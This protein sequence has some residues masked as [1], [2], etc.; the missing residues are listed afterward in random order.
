LD[1]FFSY[2]AEL[3]KT[4]PP[5]PEDAPIVARMAE[6]GIVPGQEFDRSKL[7]KLGHKLDPKLALLELVHAMK[8]KKAVDGWLYWT[9][10]AGRYGTDYEQRA[11]VTV[12]GPGMNFAE[13]AVYAFSEKDADGKDYDGS[14]HAYVMRFEQ[15]QMPPVKGFWS[16]TMYDP[17]FFFVPNPIDR[18]CLSQRDTFVTNA[19]GSVDSYLQAESPGQDREA[20]WLPA[21]KGKFIPM[22][23]LYWP[24]DAPPLDSGWIV[25]PAAAETRTV[26]GL[27]L[28][29]WLRGM[30]AYVYGFPL[31]MMDLT[32]EAATA[33]TAGEITAPVNQFAVMTKYP[34]ASFRAVARTGL[35]TLFAVAWADLEKER[36]VLSVP[37]TGG[38]YYVIAL[39]DMWS[40]V[41]ASIGKR[42]TGTAAAHSSGGRRSGLGRCVLRGR[43]RRGPGRWGSDRCLYRAR[44]AVASGHHR[45][46]VGR[47]RTAPV[48]GRSMASDANL[49]DYP[50][51]TILYAV[52]ARMALH[53]A[54]PPRAREELT[55]AQRLRP[56]LTYAL[57]HL[58]VQAR[59]ELARCHLM[60][61]DFA[62]ARILLREV[63]EV[64]MRRPDLGVFVRQAGDTRVEPSHARGSFTQGASA[65]TAAELRLLPMLPRT[66]R[67]RRSPRKC[68]SLS[69]P[70]SQR[71]TRSTGSWGSPH[72]ARRSPGPVSWG[73]WRG[74]DP[75][76]QGGPAGIPNG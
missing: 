29:P 25:D 36:L 12:I 3:L 70:S 35:D 64:L 47:S 69:P 57:P 22:L 5:K 62:A 75:V 65:L 55:R 21:P 67:F 1:E 73:S 8:T 11:M 63:D 43:G 18:Y 4:N 74:D 33:A 2:L 41:F 7:P 71:R 32:K 28:L 26:T 16:L 46:C 31:I 45:G 61:F 49:E 58:A 20:N 53:E 54:D 9:S 13:D 68:P 27:W 51:V 60:L 17:D 38:R 15:G 72:G 76:R 40:D 34:D 37:D 44:R 48:R 59:I 56:A 50:V 39:F 23:R 42:T 14:G 66:C 24:Q 10:D 19:D 30:K 52:A 6:I